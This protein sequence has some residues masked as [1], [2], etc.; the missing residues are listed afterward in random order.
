MPEEVRMNFFNCK[1]TKQ[2]GLATSSTNI[3][4]GPPHESLKGNIEY[5]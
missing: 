5:V 2:W 4:Y 3:S 1:S